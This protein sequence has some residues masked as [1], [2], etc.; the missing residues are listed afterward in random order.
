MKTVG[1]QRDI[2]MLLHEAEH[3]FHVFKK[4]NL[5]YSYQLDV[6]AE[7]LEVTSM[8]MELLAGP[9]MG[10]EKDGFYLF[11]D[12][13]RAR[14]KH[15]EDAIIVSWP[16]IA[17]MDAFQHRVY[18]NLKASE[19]RV[20]FDSIWSEIWLGFMPGGDRNGLEEELTTAWHSL[21]HF[22]GWPLSGIE[23]GIS[24]L[25]AVQIWHNALT[26]QAYAVSSYC[27]DLALGCTVSLPELFKDAGAKLVFEKTVLIQAV[28]LME[29]S[30]AVLSGQE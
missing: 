6:P 29:E 9:Y 14:V 17:T 11:E 2:V 28:D 10:M 23:Y 5:P 24:Q 12:A 8:E 15:L 25:G 27:K 13:A 1:W 21:P 7:F 3:A 22:F 26:D 18:T 4:A 16:M 30:I 20:N 19:D